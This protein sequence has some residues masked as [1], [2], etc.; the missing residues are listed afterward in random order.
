[1]DELDEEEVSALE[2]HQEVVQENSSS[3]SAG[4][5]L[6]YKKLLN[7]HQEKKGRVSYLERLQTGVKPASRAAS[8]EDLRSPNYVRMQAT[9][10]LF[11]NSSADEEVVSTA[12]ILQ[13]LL[14]VRD[15]WIIPFPE[16]E[17]S[18][19]VPPPAT[20]TEGFGS[21]EPNFDPM[22]I[23]LPNR[24][25]AVIKMIDGIYQV[26]WDPTEDIEGSSEDGDVIEDPFFSSIPLLYK[27][28]PVPDINEFLRALTDMMIAVQSPECKTF[29]F[30]RLQFL[31]ERYSFHAMLNSASELEETKKNRHRDF[32]NVR[33]VDT[34][35]HHSACMQQKHLLRFIRKKFKTDQDIVVMLDYDGTPLT[36][37]EIFIRELSLTA[38]EIST[39]SLNVHALGSCFQR[40]DRFNSK[41][42]PFGQKALREVFLKTE[43]YIE[44]RYLAEITHEVIS[45]LEDSKYQH[46]EWRISIYGKSYDEWDKLAKWVVRNNLCSKRVRWV[47]QVPRLYRLYHKLGIIKNFAELLK[48]VFEPVFKAV[49]NPKKYPEIFYLLLQTVAWDSV[50]DE[51]QISKYTM[52][53]GELPLPEKFNRG[54]N[55]PY[56][57]WG[58]YMYANIRTL[59]ELLV[60]RGLRHLEFRPHCGEAG[61]ISHLATMYLLANSINHGVMLRKSPVLQYIYYLKKIGLA[62]SPLS[63]NALF[64]E[65][66]KHPFKSF[67]EVGMNVS[68]STDDPLMFHFTDEPLLEEYSLSA[69]VWKLS[70]VDLSE[71]ARNS[72]LQSGWEPQF[73]KHWLGDSYKEGGSAGNDI[74]KTNVSNIRLQYR[75]DVFKEEH[76]YI[77]YIIRL[78]D[79]LEGMPANSPLKHLSSRL[80]FQ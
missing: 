35:V 43:N 36:L 70:P 30:Q 17:P 32:Y 2:K 55:P 14:N 57:Y 28:R 19:V 11:F 68:L 44:G 62:L 15:A 21:N 31:S 78:H 50:D 38:Y 29:C 79:E 23:P 56:S 34:H 37:K 59:N 45:D 9:W 25:N 77:E 52:K 1:M 53:G 39:D 5:N 66:N 4:W 26:F 80:G 20:F 67:F 61:S 22:V 51:S 41:Y 42:N 73:K 10:D 13:N 3:K 48:N 46:V 16:I 49:R 6:L 69:H 27:D 75:H 40:F 12:R 74:R 60:A 33:K 63:N 65:I 76:H 18:S 24:C 72:V 47:I 71:L 7:S 54:Y 8:I 58:Y 64:I